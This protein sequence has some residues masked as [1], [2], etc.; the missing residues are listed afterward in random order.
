MTTELNALIITAASI[1]FFH[2]ILGPDH[3]LPFIMMSW[4]RKWS[5]VKT[6]LI[7]LLCGLGHI[8]SSVVLG[9]IGVALGLAINKL[10]IVE[11]H[12]GN[13]AAWLLIAFGLAYFVWGLRR[14]YR[15]QPHMHGH[16]HAT[17]VSH[18]HLHAHQREHTHIHD[19][20]TTPSITPWALFV[21]FVFGPCEPLI[22]I[23]MY[24][25]AKNSLFGL[26]VV[27][28]VFGIVTIGTMLG[29]VLLSRAGVNFIPL[30]RLQ[31]FAHVIAGATICLCG[32]AIQFLGL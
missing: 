3:Y 6:T 7:T 8:G 9:L 19:A 12:R 16:S 24:P 26:L 10:E 30:S 5:G 14:A 1:G 27:T 4:A 32:L 25:A 20:K 2:T 29:M 31:R 18:T 22:P 17:W 15:K 28:C 23:L 13:L 11:S 21:I